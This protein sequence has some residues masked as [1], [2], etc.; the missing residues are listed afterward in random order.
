MS[1]P[2]PWSPLLDA[3]DYPA[4]GY[5]KLAD[6]L[7]A[8]L[9]TRNDV[10]LIQGEAIIALEAVC[11]GLARPGLVALNVVTSDYGRWYGQW[12]RHGGTQTLDIVAEPGMPIDLAAFAEALDAQPRVDI[13]MVVHAESATGILN[14]LAEIVALSKARGA[15]VVVDAV[16]SFGG[17]DL[18]VDALGIDVA[19]VGLQKALGGSAGLSALSISERAWGL[20]DDA[21][22][23]AHSVLSLN[24]LQRRWLATGRGG[25][26]GMPSALEF[27]ALAGALDRVEAEGIQA[28]IDRHRRAARATR[29][30]LRALGVEPWAHDARGSNLVTGVSL[31]KGVSLRGVLTAAAPFSVGIS[32]GVGSDLPPIVR[33]NHTGANARFERVL[34]NVVAL[35]YAMNALSENVAVGAAS[36]AIVNHYSADD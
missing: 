20:L 21:G 22:R 35:G 4:D 30:G 6:R 24:G 14:P 23:P 31:P 18:D 26:P 15:I 3:P 17:H 1:V 19:I 29:E 27:H 11:S 7:A 28:L 13:I 32:A 16:A 25:L 33:L 34:A 9:G 36:H 8:L 10:L 12:L 2:T 5:A